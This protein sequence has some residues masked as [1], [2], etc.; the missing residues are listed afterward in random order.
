MGKTGTHRFH[1][2]FLAR[3]THGEKADRPLA[4]AE[5][6]ELLLHQ[7]APHEMLAETIVGG[8]YA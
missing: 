8:L 1:G 4:L 5:Q 2:G 6:F 7:H 3:E